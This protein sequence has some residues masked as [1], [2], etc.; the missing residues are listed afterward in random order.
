MLREA[1][2]QSALIAETF[3][4][5][6]N[7]EKFRCIC[8]L[9]LLLRRLQTG[10]AFPLKHLINHAVVQF[11]GEDEFTGSNCSYI[12]DKTKTYINFTPI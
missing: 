9:V 11:H 1:G 8:G 10:H 7:I 4:S 12:L 3:A 2:K 5:Q 6:N